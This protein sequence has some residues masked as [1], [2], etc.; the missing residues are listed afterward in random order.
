MHLLC[1]SILLSPLL[2]DL[3]RADYC[4]NA[5]VSVSTQSQA[6]HYKA[7][8]TFPGSIAID[9]N[10][11][12]S[13]NLDGIEEIQGSLTCGDGEDETALKS[14]NGSI[15][16]IS[17]STLRTIGRSFRLSGLTSL[18]KLHFPALRSVGEIQWAQLPNLHGFDLGAGLDR[19]GN[20][21]VMYTGL[22]D[23]AGL[24]TR[25]VDGWALVGN[26]NLARADLAAL[27][28]YKSFRVD[29]NSPRLAVDLSGVTAA[30]ESRFAA[31][32]SVNLSSLETTTGDLALRRVFSSTMA[33]PALRRASGISL[34]IY[35]GMSV[36]FP[37]L[38]TVHGDFVVSGNVTK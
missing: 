28:T 9:P 21:S 34:Q 5:G 27:T 23:V 6:N 12:G 17:S 8:K 24:G 35:Q 11:Q 16:A 38:R 19:V 14:K 1:A 2:I 30:G 20:V 29:G 25:S 15:P 7:C 18:D 26:E 37:S 31:L 36:H 22:G 13:I 32:K 4:Q 33:F 10:F 3:T